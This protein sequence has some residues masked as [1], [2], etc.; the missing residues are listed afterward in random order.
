M[1]KPQRDQIQEIGLNKDKLL[2]V[3]P[4]ETKFPFIY[5]EAME[6]YW[7]ENEEYLYHSRIADWTYKQW[8][9][10]IIDAARLQGVLLEI[11]KSTK[12]ISVPD[13]IKEKIET[14]D[15]NER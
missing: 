7:N 6:I 14:G 1:N 12:W 15:K 4:A 8:F 10:H 5:R 11:S 3:K 2:Y 13:N 9:D